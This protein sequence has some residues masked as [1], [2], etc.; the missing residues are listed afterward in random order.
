MISYFAFAALLLVVAALSLA[1]LL[2]VT[3]WAMDGDALAFGFGI[4]GCLLC[5]AGTIAAI[6]FA[7]AAVAV[8]IES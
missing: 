6:L 2:K 1:A 8:G 3:R 7:V 5:A 4:I